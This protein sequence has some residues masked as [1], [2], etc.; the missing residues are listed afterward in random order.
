MGLDVYLYKCN[1][2]EKSQ[3]L[4]KQYSEESTKN[5]DR[6]GK[7]DDMTDEQKKDARKK[8]LEIS[9]KLGVDEFGEHTQCKEKIEIDSHK[10]PEHYFK[11]GYFRSSYNDVGTN[12][13]LSN[14]GLYDLWDIFNPGDEYEFIPDWTEALKRVDKVIHELTD[15]KQYGC[16]SISPNIF[17]K[18]ETKIKS[19]ANAISLF[20]K[21]MSRKVGFKNGYGNAAGQFFPEGIEILALINGEESILKKQQC[22]YVVTDLDTTWIEQALHIVKETILYVLGQVDKDDYYLVWSS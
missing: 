3:T 1:D 20:K 13:I 12:R 7:Y 5:W 11:I 16:F 4:E 19:K 17:S 21:E 15:E 10:Y 6:F 2:L 14:L 18:D 8:D 22:V 9:E